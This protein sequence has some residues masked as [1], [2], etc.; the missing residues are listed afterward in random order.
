MPAEPRSVASVFPPV[1]QI[2]SFLPDSNY[3][4]IPVQPLAPDYDDDTTAR[5]VLV[6]QLELPRFAPGVVV[7]SF[8]VRPDPAF[9]PNTAQSVGQR[10]SFTQDPEKGVLVFD[11]H[12][13]EPSDQ[14]LGVE[15]RMTTKAYELFVLRETLVKM[16]R[17][18]EARLREQRGLAGGAA[19]GCAIW[20]VE[21]TISWSDWG[22]K[23]SRMMDITM[24]RRNWVCRSV[25]PVVELC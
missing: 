23:G 10:K 21:K 4:I 9:P 20:R 11:L 13:L 15:D 2:Y 24:P 25:D 14:A 1:I 8:D 18:G 12:V 7:S 3:N 6:A 5:P 19:G 22:E 16:A 17:D